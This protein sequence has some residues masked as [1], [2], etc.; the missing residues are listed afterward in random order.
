M[1][2]SLLRKDIKAYSRSALFKKRTSA[3]CVLLT[4][5]LF[6]LICALTEEFMIVL[7]KSTVYWSKINTPSPN[8][9]NLLYELKIPIIVTLIS[10]L[11]FLIVVS[12]ISL[13]V[14]KWFLICSDKNKNFESNISCIFTF[15]KST[16]SILKAALLKLV[17]TILT[18]FWGI[19]F[20]SPSFIIFC[21]AVKNFCAGGDI[22]LITL[23]AITFFF[24]FLMF[25][26]VSFSIFIKRY[27]FAKYILA[28]DISKSILS[29]IFDSVKLT[30]NFK[31]DLFLLELSFLPLKLLNVLII[32]CF[33]SMPY[34]CTCRS[35]YFKYI[36]K[37]KY[38]SLC[39]Q[40]DTAIFPVIKPKTP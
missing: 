5:L 20:F 24:P 9:F 37:L 6:R 2:I 30:Q 39:P 26:F 25:S 17:L 10:F 33:F 8:V 32:P 1:S 7:S 35:V 29:C 11:I 19:L 13:G 23:C 12:P 28:D 38:E 34:I 18:A 22:S 3:V 36:Q 16:V 4:A 14:K 21:I 15:Y 31:C 27:S 40:D